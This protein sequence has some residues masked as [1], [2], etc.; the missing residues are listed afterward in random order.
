MLD[1]QASPYT[2]TSYQPPAMNTN[3][4]LTANYSAPCSAAYGMLTQYE[5]RQPDEQQGNVKAS[6]PPP[7]YEDVMK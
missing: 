1:Q 3:P 4:Y 7:S 6:A 2:Q 5:P